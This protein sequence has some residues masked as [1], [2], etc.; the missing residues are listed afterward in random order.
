MKTYGISLEATE[1]YC[2]GYV[3]RS[4]YSN[5]PYITLLFVLNIGRVE[6]AVGL[7]P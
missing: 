5:H 2:V 7:D 3:R 4:D 1:E 6:W